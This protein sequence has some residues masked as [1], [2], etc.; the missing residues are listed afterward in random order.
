[1]KEK[2]IWDNNTLSEALGVHIKTPLQITDISYDSRTINPG[3]LF[4]GLTGNNCNGSIFANEA[5]K[6]G[7]R[8]CIVDA[9]MQNANESL[10]L[11]ESVYNALLQMAKYARERFTGKIIGITGST[12]K[13]TTKEMLRIALNTDCSNIFASPGNKNN[14]LGLPLSL[15]Q[16]H[17]E[18]KFGIFELGMNRKGEISRL[19]SIL[20]PYI[21]IVTTIGHAHIGPLGSI[22]NIALAKAEIS[23]GME[24]NG[25]LLLNADAPYNNVIAKQFQKR[26]DIS[27]IYFGKNTKSD[28][29]LIKYDEMHAGFSLEVDCLGRKIHYQI[30][31]TSKH[32]IYNSLAVAATT[33]I[34]GL[35][36]QKCMEQMGSYEALE[37]RGKIHRLNHGIIVIDESY[38]A[39]PESMRAAIL[40]L[41][42]YNKKEKKKLVVILG[43]MCELGEAAPELHIALLIELNKYEVQKVFT[44]GPL[45]SEIFNKLDHKIRGV[46]TAK[47]DEL[48]TNIASYI[49]SDS[50]ILIK[51]SNTIKMAKIR[52]AIIKA[53]A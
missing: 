29:R 18:H 11:V 30:N 15:C 5:I 38:N 52:D 26:G 13:T 27:V 28:V 22:R 4:L 25:C 47:S 37:G 12:G 21:S 34:L 16:L 50:L 17:P 35:D 10:I 43:D 49:E 8:L 6:R 40:R 46:A 39:N 33:T 1:M 48:A 24:K 44:V 14:L 41:V 23:E 36:A 45:M 20:C 51:G 53:Y 31:D 9:K 42:S 2:I 3:D 7:A 19:S 32:Y